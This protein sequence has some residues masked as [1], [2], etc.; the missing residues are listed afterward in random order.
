MWKCSNVDDMVQELVF[1]P[2]VDLF[3]YL[4]IGL[5]VAV[6]FLHIIVYVA[7]VSFLSLCLIIA[8]SVS[9]AFQVCC[10]VSLVLILPRFFVLT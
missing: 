4:A 2:K 6:L 7:R 3:N 5:N 10:T 9:P 1:V 8:L